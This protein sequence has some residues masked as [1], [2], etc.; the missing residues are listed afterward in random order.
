MTKIYYGLTS[1][2][3]LLAHIR[4][5]CQCLSPNTAPQ[6]IELMIGTACAETL[7]GQYFD[8]SE[9]YGFGVM[10]FDRI[11]VKDIA[12]Y[13]REREHISDIIY[14][15][16]GFKCSYYDID[17]ICHILKFSPL[18]SCFF[19][20][21]GYMMKPEKLPPVGDLKGQAAYYKKHWNSSH[22]NAKGSEEKYIAEYRKYY[23][24][25]LV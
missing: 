23:L 4:R 19:C 24:G 11:R 10:Q 14:A 7:M 18:L 8:S 16:T 3:E 21:V 5:A 25:E 15:E 9:S 12:R 6:A 13:I 22:P 20:R 17:T 2:Q 1:Q